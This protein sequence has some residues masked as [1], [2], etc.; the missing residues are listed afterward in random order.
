MLMLDSFLVYFQETFCL[1]SKSVIVFLIQTF[2][3][4]KINY[5]SFQLIGFGFRLFNFQIKNLSR[6]ESLKKIL[7]CRFLVLDNDC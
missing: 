1:K 6:S 4:I 5:S 7:S 3:S 2:A